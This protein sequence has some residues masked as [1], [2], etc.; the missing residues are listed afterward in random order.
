LVESEETM[1]AQRNYSWSGWVRSIGRR[2]RV[3]LEVEDMSMLV[4]ES[5]YKSF[6][7]C[8]LALGFLCPLLSYNIR[9][10]PVF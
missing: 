1:V 8:T 7:F 4:R 2:F 6:W 3:I 10:G 5:G 9:L